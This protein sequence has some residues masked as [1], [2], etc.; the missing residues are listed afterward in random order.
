M[1]RN[2]LNTQNPFGL[3]DPPA[4]VLA[5]LALYD[6]LAVI[7]PSLAEPVYR[8]CRKAT[9]RAW[10]MKLP[11]GH[12][13]NPV[14]IKHRLT[15][16]KAILPSPQWGQVIPELTGFDVQR[17]GGG[18]AAADLLDEQE[19]LARRRQ[20]ADQDAECDAR[21]GTAYRDLKYHLGQTINLGVRNPEGAGGYGQRRRLTTPQAPR[22]RVY[23]PRASGDHAMFV[24]R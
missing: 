22:K 13:D 20:Q 17:V 18:T 23:R 5:D 19:D 8:F 2:F 4:H 15:P 1:S 10:W 6:P 24:G 3:A 14:M 16:L 12:L 11:A 9:G 21:S 7:F